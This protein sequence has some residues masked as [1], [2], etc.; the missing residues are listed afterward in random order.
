MD[1]RRD[2]RI[3]RELKP[4]PAALWVVDLDQIGQAR[5]RRFANLLDSA[6]HERAGRFCVAGRR[7]Q[8]IVAHGLKR[9]VLGR[10]VGAAPDTLR[11][12]LGDFGKP[13][14]I[15][16][17]SI[18]FSLA[19]CD[20]LVGIAVST[21]GKVGLD[22]EPADRVISDL[23][24][25]RYFSSV[26]QS[27]P[28]TDRIR[29]WTL[30]EAFVKATGHGITEA[31]NRHTARLSPPRIESMA[32]CT[33]WQADI[34]RHHIASVVLINPAAPGAWSERTPDDVPIGS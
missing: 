27:A 32:P 12:G 14:L 18:D 29:L 5:Q 17:E 19:H 8:H 28:R 24:V 10:T 2:K 3:I 7:L 9:L 6:E 4:A 25:S 20:G 23:I 1:W 21:S 31:F 11:F 22:L 15:S 34:A 26:E 33:A 13:Y 16:Y 30:K